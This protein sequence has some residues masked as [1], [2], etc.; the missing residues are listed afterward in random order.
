LREKLIKI[1]AKVV[2]HAREV[3]FQMAAVAIP[4]E[5]FRAIREGIG[6]LMLLTPLPG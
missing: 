6:Q 2:R 1:R 5:L 3:I 4:Q